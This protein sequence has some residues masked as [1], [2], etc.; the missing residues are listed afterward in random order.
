LR[1]LALAK[2]VKGS[3]LDDAAT[4]LEWFLDDPRVSLEALVEALCADLA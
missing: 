1:R 3:K 4:T 2:G